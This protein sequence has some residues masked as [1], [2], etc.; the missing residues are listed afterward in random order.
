MVARFPVIVTSN[1][2]SNSVNPP[3]AE[4]P[5]QGGSGEFTVTATPP[6]CFPL[7]PNTTQNL[8]LVSN[9]SL[10]YDHGIFYY[11]IGPNPGAAISATATLITGVTF[12]VTQDAGDGSFQAACPTSLD[13][14]VGRS[15]G[16][17]CMAVGG[18]SPYIWSLAS[19][20]LPPVTGFPGTA[21]NF[22]VPTTEGPFSFT[23]T[24]K[25]SSSPPHTVTIPVSGL[26]LPANPSITCS[27]GGPVQSNVPYFEACAVSGGT[28]PYQWT[29]SDGTLPNGLSMSPGPSGGIVV[30][31]TPTD[32]GNFYYVLE[33]FDTT[34]PLPLVS[35]QAFSGTLYS[36]PPPLTMKCNGAGSM[37]VVHQNF[38]QFSCLASGGIGQI[39]Y[40]VSGTLPPG[41]AFS[42]NAQSPLWIS[43]IP[44]T[45]GEYQFALQAIDSSLPTAQ[46]AQQSFD[47]TVF[48]QVSVTCTPNYGPTLVGQF[49]MTTCNVTGANRLTRS[50][51]DCFRPA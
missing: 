25:D 37:Y 51:R 9:G 1:S 36:T 48:P 35:V 18:T 11:G 34:S 19:G 6:D 23:V 44:T 50:V 4:I 29:I 15:F 30:S 10:T 12:T 42:G 49:Y 17:S 22:G 46:V 14:R 5:A 24:A 8:A 21:P 13:A 41:F 20:S 26:V 43:G 40:A 16:V 3:S 2:C 45:A 33:V 7:D 38:T 27:A 31:G 28:A 47:I 39:H 32:T